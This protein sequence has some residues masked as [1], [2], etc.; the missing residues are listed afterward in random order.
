MT[1]STQPVCDC[2]TG[3]DLC[4]WYVEG[5]VQEKAYFEMLVSQS[6]ELFDQVEVGVLDG[7]DD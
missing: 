6:P 2:V 3:P 4:S 5:Y 1:D 7:H